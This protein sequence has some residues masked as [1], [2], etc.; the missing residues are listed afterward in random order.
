MSINTE[1]AA[2]YL[3]VAQRAAERG[4]VRESLY[5]LEKAQELLLRDPVTPTQSIN[6]EKSFE[7][8][9]SVAEYMRLH[10]VGAV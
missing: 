1:T 3:M 2:S 7:R 6:G 10:R 5:H 8:S 9:L 4:D